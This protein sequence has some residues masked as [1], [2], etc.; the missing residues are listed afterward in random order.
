MDSDKG[1]QCEKKYMLHP[2]EEA[3]FNQT[4]W[5]F[6]SITPFFPVPFSQF[7]KRNLKKNKNI[8]YHIVQCS[9]KL[10]GGTQYQGHG[11]SY[12]YIWTF[13]PVLNNI[14]L[15]YKNLSLR[16]IYQMTEYQNSKVINHSQ[17]L[18]YTSIATAPFPR[19]CSN[20]LVL[21]LFILE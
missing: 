10:N 1:G 20:M 2:E 4:T 8:I 21:I 14:F 16:T 17:R 9:H 11:F 3:F 18:L 19:Y 12:S 5:C 6:V 15:G 7:E 13:N